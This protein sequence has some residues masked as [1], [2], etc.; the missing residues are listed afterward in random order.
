[1]T[2][3]NTT[4]TSEKPKDMP[5]FD[6]GFEINY[7]QDRGPVRPAF[8][9]MHRFIEAC[10]SCIQSLV[11][12]IGMSV[13]PVIV[14]ENVD[15]GSTR[16]RFRIFWK[17]KKGEIYSKEVKE[18]LASLTAKG[19]GVIVSRINVDDGSLHLQK[20][21]T[22]LQQLAQEAEVHPLALVSPV[23]HLE[24]IEIIRDFDSIKSLLAA[25]DRAE[26]VFSDDRRVVFDREIRVNISGLREEAMRET[27]SHSDP[28]MI[29]IVR[30]PD[31]L[32]DSQWLFRFDDKNLS[33]VIE[34]LEWLD[35][36]HRREEDVRPG[37]ALQ[38]RARIE[39]A[40]GY[41]SQV[42]SKKHYVE[43]I[44]RVME[45]GVLKPEQGELDF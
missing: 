3:S 7:G 27:H 16:A 5:S 24:L 4:Q 8:G 14:L 20:I 32:A 42:L 9:I 13:E 34:D 11:G 17:E 45:G 28:A 29:L 40:Y 18:A 35:R 2:I 44:A 33:A 43:K 19:I 30:K 37:D 12:S 1:M 38:C 36:F 10:E 39:V 31:Y 6:F 26:L 41:D 22:E 25:G 21:Q 15:K 23:S